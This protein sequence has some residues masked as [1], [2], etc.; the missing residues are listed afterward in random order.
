[1]GH[2]HVIVELIEATTAHTGLRVGAALDPGR[3][4][5]RVRVGDQEL[6]TLHPVA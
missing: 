4:R 3:H 5:L 6:A 2:H 1:L